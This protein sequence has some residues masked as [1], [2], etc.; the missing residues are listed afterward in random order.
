M[1]Y[2]LD[3][4]HAVS[5][6]VSETL[7]WVLRLGLEGLRSHSGPKCAGFGLEAF[8]SKLKML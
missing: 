4:S 7:K 5:R 3:T 1:F 8:V 2:G 6:Q